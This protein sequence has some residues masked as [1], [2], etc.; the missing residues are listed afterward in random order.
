MQTVPT[1]TEN[2]VRV[3]GCAHC[4]YTETELV[5]K[6]GHSY[7]ETW[8]VDQAATCT[9]VGSESRHCTRT[10]CQ[11]ITAQREIAKLAHDLSDWEEIKAPNCLE[12]GIEKRT[13]AD[14]DYAETRTIEKLGHAYA[15]EWTVDQAATC[16]SVGVESRHCTRT[17]CH[18]TT[19]QREIAKL[20]HRY[21]GGKVTLEATAGVVGIKTYTCLDCGHA[22]T[23][24]IAKLAPSIVDQTATVWEKWVDDGSLQ[25]RSNASI[26]DFV[27]VR[28][29][30][31]ILPADCYTLKEG[32]IIV[33]LKP[34]YLSAL[35]KGD[36][37]LEI[38]SENGVAEAEFTI[39]Q[40][41]ISN[42]WLYGPAIAAAGIILLSVAIWFVFFKKKLFV[43]T[44]NF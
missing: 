11:A 5:D 34:E 40:N 30:N 15:E 23:E 3:R 17:D 36:Y 21:D 6:L 13:C 18:S 29:N 1:C 19:D 37:K 28:L 33:E 39:H 42:P 32:S 35:G 25:F 22:Y 9:R 31:E 24:E 8:T 7:A 20:D 12:E 2:G 26:E 4:S 43:L 14:C 27:E 38:V 10:D 41:P 16:T 44:K